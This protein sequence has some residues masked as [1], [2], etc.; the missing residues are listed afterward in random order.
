MRIGGSEPANDQL[1]VNANGGDD[2][3]ALGDGLRP[4][5][6]VNVIA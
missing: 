1:T 2:R 3:L 6:K 4:L 5:I